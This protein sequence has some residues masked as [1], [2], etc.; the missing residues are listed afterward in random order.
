MKFAGVE[1]MRL[2]G[3][4]PHQFESL[5]VAHARHDGPKRHCADSRHTLHNDGVD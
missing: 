5:Q 1:H 3:C 2:R 4:P